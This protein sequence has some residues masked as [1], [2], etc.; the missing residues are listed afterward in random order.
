MCAEFYLMKEINN[1]SQNNQRQIILS[2]LLELWT[3]LE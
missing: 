3:C 2:I 1:D